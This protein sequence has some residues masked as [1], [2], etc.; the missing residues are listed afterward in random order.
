MI[1]K[2]EYTHVSRHCGLDP[3]SLANSGKTSPNPS[4]GGESPSLLGR[5]GERFNSGL[6]RSARNDGNGT[7]CKFAPAK[8]NFY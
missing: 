8:E 4:K 6:L 2:K 3:Q 1:V 5:A 7:S